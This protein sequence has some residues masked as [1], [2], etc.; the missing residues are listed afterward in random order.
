MRNNFKPLGIAAAV[1]AAAAGY[2]NVASAQSAVANNSLG[3][4]ALVPYYTVENNFITG[5][6]VVNTSDRTQ[7]VKFRLRRGT[8][9]LD[10]L[11]FNIVMSP[12][13]VW[14]GFISKDADGDI[15]FKANDTTCSVPAPSADGFLMP[16]IYREGA[17]TGYIEVIAM[18]SPS[19][20]NEPDGG[21]DSL[22]AQAAK[23][24]DGVPVDCAA[25][26]SNFFADAVGA[27][28]NE[29]AQTSADEDLT[30]TN[31]YDPSDDV[32]KVSYFIRN[33]D[34]G[35]EFGNNAVH[36]QGFLDLPAITNQEL[37]Y[38]SGDLNGFDFPDLNGGAPLGGDTGKFNELREGDVLGVASLIN[39]W[40]ANPTNG[41]STDWVVTMPGQ[42]TMLDMPLYLAS[43]DDP[44]NDPCLPDVCDFRD[45]PV[46]ASIS[47]YDREEGRPT[48]APGELVVS[49]SVPGENPSTTFSKE[50]N[51]LTF[52]G[53]GTNGVLGV[54]DVDIDAGLDQ[55]YGWLAL[56]VT[57]STA[58]T[59]SVC[60]W[61]DADT[62]SCAPV[63][64]GNV[65]IIGFTAWERSFAAN[66]D[67]NY[68]RIIEH[69]FAIGSTN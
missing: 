5:V 37:G 12:E 35:V 19:Q 50:V 29:T 18:G 43:L 58:K 16:S 49:P 1:A 22:I 42:Y 66:P 33:A 13:D 9:S 41:V 45:L 15:S 20:D 2:A 4:L 52:G 32:L 23:H 61:D 10:A 30:G 62:M 51:V 38:L 39:E 25:V 14:A 36:I 55:P 57:S 47:A 46:T 26:R 21:D 6:H 11:D 65:P 64:N 53:N 40:S 68:G 3:D 8:D 56:G 7:V 60:D 63:T 44:E 59:Q 17:D 24:V 27:M 34:R 48:T 69:S 67:A 31:T 54:S 28:N